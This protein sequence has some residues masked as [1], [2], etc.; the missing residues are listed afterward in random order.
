MTTT[1]TTYDNIEKHSTEFVIS[2]LDED[3]ARI[4]DQ[5]F[6]Q[7]ELSLINAAAEGEDDVLMALRVLHMTVQKINRLDNPEGAEPRINIEEMQEVYSYLMNAVDEH[8][9]MLHTPP[10]DL[11]ALY[12]NHV[13]TN[14]E[15]EGFGYAAR[16]IGGI[17]RF[18]ALYC[19]WAEIGKYVAHKLSEVNDNGKKN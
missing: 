3:I 17:L 13:V 4:A 12:V 2:I 7:N 19:G 18:L 16:S 11:D 14:L 10:V 1:I 15:L 5:D 8:K 9:D 6:G